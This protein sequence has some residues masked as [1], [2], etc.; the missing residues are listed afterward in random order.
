MINGRTSE[1]DF[2]RSYAGYECSV[3]IS[4][5][6]GLVQLHVLWRKME[7]MI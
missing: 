4:L 7:L 1:E 6:V 2:V 5:S 3:L